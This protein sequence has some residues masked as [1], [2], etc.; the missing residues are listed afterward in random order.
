MLFSIS[1]KR[2]RSCQFF[3]K[4]I[5]CNKIVRSLDY[6]KQCKVLGCNRCKNTQLT[7]RVLYM[8]S[9]NGSSGMVI[10]LVLLVLLVPLVV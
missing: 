8:P 3:F 2:M 4:K 10:L 1:K 9:A 5:V 7:S 6:L